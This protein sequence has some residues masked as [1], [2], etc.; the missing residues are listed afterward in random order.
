M[1]KR[2]FLAVAL[3][4][5]AV[6]IVACG[7]KGGNDES[8][9]KLE[10]MK[11]TKETAFEV[12]GGVLISF[13]DNVV[14]DKKIVI[15]ESINGEVITKIADGAFFENENIEGILIPDSISEIGEQAFANCENL[16]EV[17]LSSNLISLPMSVFYGTAI[18]GVVIP[19]SVQS[20]GEYAFADCHS[21]KE[22]SIP[23]SVKS[24]DSSS[25]M[26]TYNLTSINVA[27]ENLNFSSENGVLFNKEKTNLI[28]YPANK[29]DSSYIV[30]SGVKEVSSS[31]FLSS[32]NLKT[33][34]L[35]D[36][37]N[38]G[39]IAFL[40]SENLEEVIFGSDFAEPYDGFPYL[41][42][43][44][45]KIKRIEI[46]E[47]NEVFSTVDGAVYNKDKTELIYFPQVM[48]NVIV[49]IP[50][51][52]EKIANAAF[53]EHEELRGV[54]FSDTVKVIGRGAF[55]GCI[56]LKNVVVPDNVE[57]VETRAFLD[58]PRMA[59]KLPDSIKNV[60]E[61]FVDVLPD[62]E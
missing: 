52:V 9:M 48:E 30:P 44:C 53:I 2:F 50:V 19:E 35:S 14:K 28:K 27:E 16:S 55:E 37:E 13:K 46:A 7:R 22:I 56:N 5:L 36:V 54:V 47:E 20:I 34:N 49:N 51:G 3:F 6:G 1:K 45:N 17:I 15:P 62:D 61:I 59:V 29:E 43:G 18:E 38:V 25:F 58:V 23:S 33:I 24:I 21:L 8:G 42:R 10:N 57:T 40:D 60:E 39:S 12:E 32:K 41:F 31:A 11:P 26:D 4:I